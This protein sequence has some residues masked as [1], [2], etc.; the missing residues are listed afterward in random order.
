MPLQPSPC[1]ELSAGACA[2]LGTG[3]SGPS[4]YRP[5]QSNAAAS[6]STRERSATP[7]VVECGLP[8]LNPDTDL[9]PLRE[10][11]TEDALPPLP[12]SLR[13]LL[14]PLLGP[15]GGSGISST[16]VLPQWHRSFVS[17][18]YSPDYLWTLRILRGRSCSRHMPVQRTC[19]RSLASLAATPHTVFEHRQTISV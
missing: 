10:Q 14:G 13:P 11:N 16:P 7:R 15:T 18:V 6:E 12:A 2:Q 5:F 3:I 9:R 1:V 4:L 17:L 19:A 8:G